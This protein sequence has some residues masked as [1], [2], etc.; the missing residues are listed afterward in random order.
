M[1]SDG[2]QECMAVA[3]GRS[4]PAIY[5]ARPDGGFRA[6]E[7]GAIILGPPP[8]AL[9]EAFLSTFTPHIRTAAPERHRVMPI[10]R[11]ERKA[12]HAGC[13]A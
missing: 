2:V 10:T 3:W 6:G 7:R 5:A 8:A 4:I 9:S 11:L 12:R 13:A 1:I